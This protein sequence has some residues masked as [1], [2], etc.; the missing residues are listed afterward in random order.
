MLTKVPNAMLEEFTAKPCFR[1]TLGGTDAVLPANSTEVIP[2]SAEALDVGGYFDPVTYR[3]TPPAG[4]YR[5]SVRGAQLDATADNEILRVSLFKN[6]AAIASQIYHGI[7]TG[8]SIPFSLSTVVEANG[9]DYFDARYFS[10][11]LA[12]TKT[13]EGDVLYTAFEGEAV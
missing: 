6:G 13:I 9:T 11:T 1:A 4:K 10:F 7:L 12:G 2:F 8:S 5:L 3:F